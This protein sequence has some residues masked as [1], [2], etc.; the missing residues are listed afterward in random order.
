MDSSIALL[1][2]RE[3]CRLPVALSWAGRSAVDR[4]APERFAPGRGWSR[5][6]P[7][8][9]PG[10]WETSPRTSAALGSASLAIG[11]R[12][13]P[14][15]GP[16]GRRADWRDPGSAA[17]DPGSAAGGTPSKGRSGRSCGRRRYSSSTGDSRVDSP[18][19]VWIGSGRGRLSDPYTRIVPGFFRFR[20]PRVPRRRPARGRGPSTSSTAPEGTDTSSTNAGAGPTES[21]RPL[22]SPS[23]GSGI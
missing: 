6:S 12:L 7:E 3:F 17:G 18:P 10:N 14:I 13:S 16:I 23:D 11:R 8:R 19:A 9:T 22:R 21:S 4:L 20:P 5:S 2:S 1:R 15:R